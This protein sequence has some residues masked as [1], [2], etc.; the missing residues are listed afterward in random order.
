LESH[1]TIPTHFFFYLGMPK[2]SFTFHTGKP[3]KELHKD[4]LEGKYPLSILNYSTISIRINRLDI[5]TEDDKSR[6]FEYD[7]IV[8]AIDNTGIKVTNRDQWMK[9]KWHVKKKGYL[10]S[11]YQ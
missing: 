5:K 2:R 7:C 11:T 6:T 4:M 9:D 3:K 1:F 8:V 10:K